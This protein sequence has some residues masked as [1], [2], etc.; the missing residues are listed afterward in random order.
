MALASL[1]RSSWLGAGL[2]LS[3]AWPALAEDAAPKQK[4]ADAK[5][6]ASVAAASSSP[7]EQKARSDFESFAREWMTKIRGAAAAARA[8]AAKTDPTAP[9]NRYP[10]DVS[11]ELRPTTSAAAPFVGLIKYVE[12]QMACKDAAESSCQVESATRV[13]EIFRYQGGKWIY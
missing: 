9:F 4:A 7:L 3:L 6:A 11:T 10:E 5:P 8:G 1:R 12:E 2:M 13:T